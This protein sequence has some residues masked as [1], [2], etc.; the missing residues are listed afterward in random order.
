MK[1]LALLLSFL[2]STVTSAQERNP[3]D[4]TRLLIPVTLRDVH[5][6]NGSLWTT[7]WTVFNG[8]SATLDLVGPFV[9]QD[10]TVPAGATRKLALEQGFGGADGAFVY[11][12]NAQF[13]AMAHTLR[14]RDVSVDA[15]SFGTEIATPLRDDFRTLVRLVDIPTD[16]RYRATL[17][18]Y[19]TFETP[20]TV[21]MNIYAPD[22]AEPLESRQVALSGI[23]HVIEEPFPSHPAYAQVDLLTP[24]LRAAAPSL[25]V[26]VSSADTG[27]PV[28]AFV[29]ITNDT[30]QQVTTVT[31]R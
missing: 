28:W 23:V 18:I 14:A 29:S 21:R 20:L 31:P 16:A 2:L 7:E 24:S 17:R 10:H 27:V 11:V 1:K 5:G 22:R 25:R 12:P 8:S 26:E 3:G 15:Q 4:Y 9:A 13:A 6:A 19:S 30:T